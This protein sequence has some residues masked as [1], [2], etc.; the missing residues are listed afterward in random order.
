MRDEADGARDDE[1]RV[2]ELRIDERADLLHIHALTLHE[3]VEEQGRHDA[4]DIQDQFAV[5]RSRHRFHCASE[6]IVRMLL[7]E[8]RELCER[9]DARIRNTHTIFPVAYAR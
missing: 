2:E 1:E 9:F 3:D 8:V 7:Q 6:V 4:V 5:L